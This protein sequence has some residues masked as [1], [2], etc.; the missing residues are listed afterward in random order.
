MS[1]K[2]ILFKYLD[3][4]K[5]LNLPAGK[6]AIFGSGPLAVRNI[7][8]PHDADIVVKKDLWDILVK[9]YSPQMKGQI[10][11]LKIG[12]NIEAYNEWINFTGRMDEIID[13]AQLIE[14]LPFVKLNYVLEWKES[15]GREKDINDIKLIKE[16]LSKV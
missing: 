14:G 1:P 6:F 4:L 3:E 9:K 2:D 15:V 5:D 11:A 8:E 7:R 13:S 16:Y 10:T 12:N